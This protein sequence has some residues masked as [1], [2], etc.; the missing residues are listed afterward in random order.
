VVPQLQGTWLALK[1]GLLSVTLAM[2]LSVILWVWLSRYL[3][4]MPYVNRLV[5]STNVGS[6]PDAGSDAGR[7]AVESAWP[8]IGS[9]GVAVTDLRPGGVARFYDPIVN[10]GRNAD[11]I[12]SYG[13]VPAGTPLVVQRREGPTIYVKADDAATANSTPTGAA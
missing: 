13:F 2:T 10:D 9:T 7:E 1:Q 6:T 5:L 3:P 12:G 11:V 8:T 4:S